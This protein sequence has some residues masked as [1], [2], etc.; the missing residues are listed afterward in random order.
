MS[1]DDRRQRLPKWAQQE[2]QRL[3]RDL[4]YAKARLAQGPEDSRV[5]ADPYSDPPRPLG[6]DTS[7]D[8]RFGDGW[9]DR[10]N[11]RIDDG[12]IRVM[13]GSR[14]VVTPEA[15]NVIRIETRER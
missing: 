11:V 2:L 13:G 1:S 10:I 12:G 14:L 5:I 15:S 9:S 6:S 4:A 8:F 7:I 3:E